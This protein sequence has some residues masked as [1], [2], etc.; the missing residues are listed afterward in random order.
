MRARIQFEVKNFYAS[1]QDYQTTLKCQE[2]NLEA[3]LELATLYYKIGRKDKSLSFLE[4]FL[5][6][7]SK[8]NYLKNERKDDAI[9][10]VKFHLAVMLYKCNKY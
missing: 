5:N 8:E 9:K 3:G 10:Q 2:D 1:I 7:V 4:S 6:R